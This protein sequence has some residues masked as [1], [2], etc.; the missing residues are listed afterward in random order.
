MTTVLGGL[1][2][3]S[4]LVGF[5]NRTTGVTAAGGTID[6]TGAVGSPLNFAFSSP[7]TGTITSMAAY[8]STTASLALIGTTITVTAQ[9]YISTTPDNIFTPV[10]GTLVTLSPAVTGVV[11][12]GTISN[13]LT[14]GLSIAVAPEA[15]C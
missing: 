14:T 6:L 15:V 5:G 13:G 1:T 3:S 12:I 10:P 8:F 9:L 7:R 2:N 11:S 4:S